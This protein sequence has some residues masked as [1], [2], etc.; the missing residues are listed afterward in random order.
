MVEQ[1]LKDHSSVWPNGKRTM[2]IRCCDGSRPRVFLI[3]NL[4][5]DHKE[6]SEMSDTELGNIYLGLEKESNF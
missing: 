6:V 3:E 2:Q 1:F 5:V 4:E